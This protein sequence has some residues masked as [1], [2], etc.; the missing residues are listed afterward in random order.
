MIGD[1][2]LRNDFVV[3]DWKTITFHNFKLFPRFCKLQNIT[4]LHDFQKIIRHPFFAPY[5]SIIHQINVTNL[6]F[7]SMCHNLTVLLLIQW[8]IDPQNWL[9]LIFYSKLTIFRK[10]WQQ[11]FFQQKFQSFRFHLK[12][13]YYMETFMKIYKVYFMLSQKTYQRRK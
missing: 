11:F 9:T 12:W 13:Y 7:L 10:L 4:K 5:C 1:F 3:Y 2:W 8:I 6:L